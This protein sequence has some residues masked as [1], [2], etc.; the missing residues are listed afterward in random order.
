MSQREAE[1]EKQLVS[2]FEKELEDLEQ[3]KIQVS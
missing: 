1:D 2:D 3:T